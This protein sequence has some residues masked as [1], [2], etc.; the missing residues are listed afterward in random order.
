MGGSGGSPLSIQITAPVSAAV[1]NDIVGAVAYSNQNAA[2]GEVR[3]LLVLLD[4]GQGGQASL[5]V[6]VIAR[7]ALDDGSGDDHLVG[8]A[9]NDTLKGGQGND[10]LEGA[11]GDD[12][13]DGGEGID[14]TIGGGGSDWHYVDN[15]DDVVVEGAGEGTQDRVFASVDFAL[16]AGAEVEILSTS[17]DGGTVS[18][19]LTGN[20]FDNLI[21]AM[22]GPIS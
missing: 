15:V 20:E 1:L 22:P 3:E 13:L 4:D 12:R 21:S 14:V 8:S 16:A 11:A 9:K 10:R 5:A 19:N 6:E 17:F 18:I 7:L 2:A